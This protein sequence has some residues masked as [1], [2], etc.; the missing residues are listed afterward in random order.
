MDVTTGSQTNDFLPGSPQV[1]VI[2]GL[3]G[4]DTTTGVQSPDFTAGNQGDDYVNANQGDDTVRG[5]RGD[6]TVRGG[7]GDDTVFGGRGSDTVFGDRGDDTL[8]GG[9]GSQVPVGNQ[10]QD[11]MFGRTGNDLLYGNEG[12]DTLYGGKD[13]D[14]AYGGKDDDWVSGDLGSDTL[15]GDLGNDTVSG[16]PDDPTIAL[17]DTK[18]LLFGNAGNDYLN[19]NAG[20]DNVFGGQ[21]DDVVRG[22]KNNDVVYGDIGNDFVFGDLGDDTILGGTNN[23]N[24]LDLQGRD[25]LSGGAGND[26]VNGNEN[27]DTL[28]GN[29]GCDTVRGG[30]GNDY[31]EG[32]ECNDALFGDQG[33]DTLVGG[34]GKDVFVIGKTTGSLQLTG[35]DLFTDF[36][37]TI[38]L[39]GLT[40]GQTFAN[41]NLVAGT[42]NNVGNT[43]LQDKQNG[44]YL[45]ILQGTNPNQLSNAQ[46]TT[47][48]YP[49][50][51]C[52][53]EAGTPT[54]SPA[55]SPGTP[56]PTPVPPIVGTPT[57]TPAPGETPTPTPAPTPTP[58]SV[59]LSNN[60]VEENSTP[61]TVV[62]TI[63][64]PDLGTEPPTYTLVE[65]ADGR[66]AIDG[67]QIK[68]A[69]PTLDYETDQS[70]TVT[71][72]STDSQGNTV[73]EDFTIEVQ[74]INDTPTVTEIADQTARA[75]NPFNFSLEPNT[76]SDQDGDTLTYSATLADGTPLPSWLT[77]NPQT[78]TFSG[79]P[80][81]GDVGSLNVQIT[82]D[83]GN[84]G[85]V[86]DT[87]NLEVTPGNQP[88][89]LSTVSKTG[90]ENTAI[91]FTPED[92]SDA[93]ADADGD[94]LEAIVIT[95]LP[96]NGSLTLN[97]N[98]VAVN[99]EIPIAEI[100]N[101]NFTPN[102]NFAGSTSFGWNASDGTTLAEAGAEVM[103][104]VGVENTPP[105]LQ[106]TLSKT[107]TED[108]AIAFTSADFNN[109]FNDADG[110]ILDRI[111]IT[112]LPENGTLRLGDAEVMLNQEIPAIQLDQLT[113]VPD[114]N[115][116]GTAS[117]EWNGFDGMTYAETPGTVNLTVESVNDPPQLDLNGEAAG[118]NY[119]ANFNQA[120][121]FVSIVD[122]DN[123]T[124]EDA[125]S[126]TLAGATVTI[127]NPLD[128][129]NEVLAVV[130]NGTNIT[131][132]YADGVLTLTGTD[133]VENYQQV[134]RSVTYNN[135]TPNATPTARLI[136][137][138]VTDGTDVSP[139]ATST[140]AINTPA[141]LALSKTASNDNPTI[142]DPLSYTLT[143]TNQ[144]TE[145]ATN[146]AITEYLPNWLNQIEFTPNT[147]TYDP[148]TGIWTIPNLAGGAST[149]LQ[150][151]GTLT[152]WGS[153]PNRAQITDVDQTDP[154]S[155]PNNYVA[156]EDDLALSQPQATLPS[157]VSL[158][159]M[160][161]G[162]GGFVLYGVDP[163]DASGRDVSNA[164]DLNGDGFKDV[165][166]GTRYAD[167]ENNSATGAGEA[168]V[169]YGGLNSGP[170]VDLATLDG[171][172]GFSLYGID[173][174]DYAG[175]SVANGG[176]L[177]GD[178]V[179]DLVVTARFADGINNATP[180]SGE[181]YVVFGGQDFGAS[182]NFSQLNGTNGFTL[183]GVDVG[184]YSGRSVANGG[185]INGDGFNDLMI[186]AYRSDGINNATPNAG[187]TYIVF[188]GQDFSNN[189]NLSQ[190]NG[191]NGLTIY[192]ID[193]GD[194]SGRSV[195]NAGDV[196][197]DGFDDII[198]GARF[199]DGLDNSA[200]DAGEAYLVYG[201]NN[202][203][204]S[205]DLSQLNG[206][207]GFAI[208]GVD[209]GDKL[210]RDVANA[211]DINGDGYS[212][213]IIGAYD[214]D[215][216]GNNAPNAGEAYIVFG[217]VNNPSIDLSQL[218][219]TNGFTLYGVN[220]G[221]AAGRDVSGPGDINGDGY[222][223]L[224]VSAP[225][226]DGIENAQS[227]A[228]D[229][230]VIFGG[231][232][233]GTSLDLSNLT[234]PQG[235]NL[236][237]I[238]AGDN[239]GRAVG[240][241]DVNG[242]GFDDLLLGAIGG[243]DLNNETFNAGDNYVVYG[244]DFTGAVTQHGGLG[245]DRFT[246]TA[247]ADVL[248]G[249]QDNDT[250][251]GAG[252]ADVVMGGA[253]DDLIA[254]S[255][256]SFRRIR[257]GSGV[258]TLRLDGVFDINLTTNPYNQIL[259]IEVID[260]NGAGAHTLTLGSLDVRDLSDTSRTVTVLG[261]ADDAVV[262]NFAGFT[263]TSA[264]GFTTY[265]N[266]NIN[267]VVQETV[268][269][270]GVVV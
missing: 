70:H 52:D 123:L 26:Y 125:D 94:T 98:P 69:T 68:V 251:I 168:Y 28:S 22:G 129:A 9:V 200:T 64:T 266:G 135:T 260:L 50:C 259:G 245:A 133:T 254:V 157:A 203:G 54:P 58:G 220:E 61:G 38:D 37:P 219:G 84:G 262:G 75:G 42:G 218:D 233:V 19:G 40:E 185:D 127:T 77:F 181:T 105:T 199:A 198:I 83:D 110:D 201:G 178:G 8:I 263:S 176:D 235:F 91:A 118:I 197:N 190:L 109:A 103:L 59:T 230:Y 6:D 10:V 15:Y 12:N 183:Y 216:L 20:D 128:D 132:N 170:A 74:D 14:I 46:F 162:L 99:Q 255:D 107:G 180:E 137:F 256:D 7:K 142:G 138:T 3:G 241:G 187:E 13:N 227:N 229:S 93:F 253:G 63:T 45:A 92:F 102:P 72:Q 130:P 120:D 78:G 186:G 24:R 231:P 44:Q 147:G 234:M 207:N 242:D 49:E 48:L 184:D 212:D 2:L 39:I 239:S 173:A 172:Q 122:S 139:V 226:A 188:G 141:D 144:G 191:T 115:F 210:G 213:L 18:D 202:L 43:I 248:I 21:D 104:A 32:N 206:T 236:Y 53:D 177:N 111:V 156:S 36:N 55:P 82:A 121:G 268:N 66:F 238:D 86:S 25:F 257:G 23:P 5:G 249:A 215:G 79:T 131:A 243:D 252:G 88:P 163:E 221:D 65:D 97:G 223:D 247:E 47:S 81:A 87:F 145:P 211:G 196:N 179:D 146:I 4:D 85:T 161:N 192:G 89:M 62:G 134:L 126:P 140:V 31:I 148:T 225:L 41:L 246:G 164:G 30:R 149:T 224:L 108:T 240:A 76:F 117:F 250:L 158:S 265:T 174:G 95:S 116:N 17:E 267:L 60:T 159:N 114:A 217:G 204:T 51:D 35:A 124:I 67:D 154:D 136:E 209:T 1:D 119:T 106:P 208:Y 152:R 143:L 57:P 71:V 205:I 189:I 112:S 167:G 195:A 153:I 228:G 171:T 100:S 165:V 73:E 11:I 16:A 270:A 169:V 237:G 222:D 34:S 101:L 113:F 166:I 33:T 155:T 264:N 175:R 182:L 258:D 193:E 90:D 261:G 160:T 80:A 27:D 214:A 269:Q 150:I 29:D 151:N 194:E 244:G 232:N 96:E 56:S